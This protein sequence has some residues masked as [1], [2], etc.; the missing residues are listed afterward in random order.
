MIKENGFATR[1]NRPSPRHAV[2]PE[3]VTTQVHRERKERKQKTHSRRYKRMQLLM[4]RHKVKL[5]KERREM[6][7]K[8]KSASI[9]KRI[10]WWFIKAWRKLILTG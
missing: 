2:S 6:D 5:E 8:M 9:F 3:T 10:Q 7:E 1:K 4:R